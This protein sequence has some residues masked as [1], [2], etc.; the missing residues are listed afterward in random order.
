MSNTYS[1]QEICDAGNKI[2]DYCL[3]T[4]RSDGGCKTCP[5]RAS[6]GSIDKCL[7]NHFFPLCW[8]DF[9]P[10]RWN[11]NDIIMAQKF[12]ADGYESIIKVNDCESTQIIMSS[13]KSKKVKKISCDFF[14]SLNPGEKIKL[15]DIV[16][17]G[18]VSNY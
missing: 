7:F 17:D 12:L 4:S 11:E 3:H 6:G 18:G 14:P 13:K 5:F 2:K 9:K 10:S 1:Q 16:N 15:Q 8:P